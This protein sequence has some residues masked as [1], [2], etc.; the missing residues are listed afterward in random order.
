MAEARHDG[1]Q[2]TETGAKAPELDST[3]RLEP[4]EKKEER[5]QVGREAGR[6]K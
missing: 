4:E 2:Q 1:R 5:K 6:H 3:S